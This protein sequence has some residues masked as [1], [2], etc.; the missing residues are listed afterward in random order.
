MEINVHKSSSLPQASAE[1]PIT[2]VFL[3][4]Q[5]VEDTS[6]SRRLLGFDGAV[7]A[8]VVL[9]DEDDEKSL[10]EKTVTDMSIVDGTAADLVSGRPGTFQT[11][12]LSSDPHPVLRPPPRPPDRT[13][14]LLSSDHHPVL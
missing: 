13:T 2:M 4:Y 10:R 9:I 11:T 1:Q 5:D 6:E 3:G 14:A 12:T 8:E 7:K